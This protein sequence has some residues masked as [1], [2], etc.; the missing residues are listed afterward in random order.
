M[1]KAK[2]RWGGL[3]EEQG[4][5]DSALLITAQWLIWFKTEPTT[6]GPKDAFNSWLPLKTNLNHFWFI[7]MRPKNKTKQN[8]NKKTKQK[9]T[10]Q[11]YINTRLGSFII[12]VSHLFLQGLATISQLLTSICSATTTRGRHK[13]WKSFSVSGSLYNPF[14]SHRGGQHLPLPSHRAAVLPVRTSEWVT[15]VRNFPYWRILS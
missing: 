10:S 1:E 13:A 8:K 4:R 6:V 2:E 7:A 3:G 5:K 15:Q 14:P 11:I 9:K 12:K